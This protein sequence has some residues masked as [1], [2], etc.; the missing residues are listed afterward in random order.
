M[1]ARADTNCHNI[2]NFVSATRTHLAKI[3]ATRRVLADMS[4]TF[5]AKPERGTP[6]YTWQSHQLSNTHGS[7]LNA[8]IRK[9]IEENEGSVCVTET[10]VGNRCLQC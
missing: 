10:S 9:E 6:L 1:S 5:P 3:G 7:C 2:F 8:K 4:A